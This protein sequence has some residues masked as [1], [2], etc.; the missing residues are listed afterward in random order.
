[1][2]ASAGARPACALL[3]R[4]PSSEASPYLAASAAPAGRAG[5]SPSPAALPPS[6]GRHSPGGP[7]SLLGVPAH[8]RPPHNRQGTL[9][10]P[11]L[12]APPQH[13]STT[14]ARTTNREGAVFTGAACMHA[15]CWCLYVF[16]V[17]LF[18]VCGRVQTVV[19]RL[20]PP[21]ARHDCLDSR[22]YGR[23]SR[24]DSSGRPH[25]YPSARWRSIHVSF[26]K[27]NTEHCV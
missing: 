2:C 26:F 8:W 7:Y 10:P 21:A 12:P 27:F 17:Y 9:T 6:S 5:Q 18:V 24:D 3:T 22:H 4:Q 23:S 1:M 20:G 11:S 13:T 14:P 25:C 15:R 19:N 16:K